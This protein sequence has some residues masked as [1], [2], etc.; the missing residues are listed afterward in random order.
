MS[1]VCG[2]ENMYKCMCVFVYVCLRGHVGACG[3]QRSVVGVVFR[4]FLRFGDGF[5]TEPRACWFSCVPGH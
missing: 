1:V 2:G 3:D 5:F 4:H